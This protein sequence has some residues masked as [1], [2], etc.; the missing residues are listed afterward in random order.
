MYDPR[1]GDIRLVCNRFPSREDNRRWCAEALHR[2]VHEANR[3]APSPAFLFA[4]VA[5][6]GKVQSP[7]L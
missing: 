4:D 2:L 7:Y 6:D 1:T 5:G 3:L